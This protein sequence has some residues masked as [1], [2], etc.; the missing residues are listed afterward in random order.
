MLDKLQRAKSSYN[1]DQWRNDY[2][3]SQQLQRMIRHNGDRYC[4]N[5]Y[6]LHSVCTS[7]GPT[8]AFTEIGSV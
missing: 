6:F 4:K 2:H 3:K 5:P 7:N 1:N 8:K